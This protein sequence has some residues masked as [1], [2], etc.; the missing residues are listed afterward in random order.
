LILKPKDRLEWL[1]MRQK[2]G[3]GGSDAGTVL[4][5]NPWC[6]NVQL[7]RY[8]T[9]QEQPEDISDK[10]AVKFGKEAERH[11]RALFRLDYPSFEVEYAEY[12]MYVNDALPWQFATLDGALTDTD[13]GRR[14]ILEIKTTTIQNKA[15]WDE[16]ENGIPQRYYAQVLHQ[17]SA[18]GWDFAIVRAYIR[19]YK[20]GELRVTVRDYRIERKDVLDDI[21]YL[22]EQEQRF[23]DCV[24][25][26]KPPAAI[27]TM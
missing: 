21:A 17:L 15:Q 5:L 12:D 6:S 22:C 7:W 27:I 8:K 16:W 20:D 11:I 14:G 4:G 18:T 3:I 19:W 23:I 2:V 24:N 1:A 10:P 26:G 9:G 25:S 13:T